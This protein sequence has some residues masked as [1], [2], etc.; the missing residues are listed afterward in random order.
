MRLAPGD[1]GDTTAPRE[2]RKYMLPFCTTSFGRACVLAGAVVAIGLVF[3]GAGGAASK[4]ICAVPSTGTPPNLT[5]APCA[6]QFVGPHFTS[7]A[8]KA[9][10]VTQSNIE[11][12]DP[13]ATLSVL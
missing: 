6:H 1:G 2:R 3:A 7:P 11:S 12:G 13:T 4:T 8:C 9:L 5:G 10:S